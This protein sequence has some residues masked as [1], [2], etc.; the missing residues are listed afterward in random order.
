MLYDS[1]C[2][3]VEKGTLGDLLSVI[4]TGSRP[5]GGAWA[6]GI[7]SVGVETIESFGGYDFSNEKYISEEFFNNLK[8]G[9]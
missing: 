5:K 2:V 7:P 1:L 4:E 9:R 3:G 8:R 6:D